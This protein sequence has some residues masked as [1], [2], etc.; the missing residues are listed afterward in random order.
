VGA[1]Q[2][3]LKKSVSTWDEVHLCELTQ[4]TTYRNY[5]APG[6]CGCR[7]CI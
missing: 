2:H 1:S 4:G 6:L 5:L 7:E 3:H